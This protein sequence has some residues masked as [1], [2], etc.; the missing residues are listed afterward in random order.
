MAASEINRNETKRRERQQSSEVESI[1]TRIKYF[2]KNILFIY[3]NRM[4]IK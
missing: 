4:F 3:A 1:Y 2:A